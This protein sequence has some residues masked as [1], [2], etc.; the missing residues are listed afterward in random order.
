M[1]GQ[2]GD[3]PQGRSPRRWL[4]ATVVVVAVAVIAFSAWSLHE[5]AEG[6]DPLAWLAGQPA[7]QTTEEVADDSSGSEDVASTAG[8]DAAG[9]G[10]ASAEAGGDATDEATTDDGAEAADDDA[11]SDAPQGQDDP[12][13]ST[14]DAPSGG[15]EP[16]G[17]TSQP[18]EAET[19]AQPEPAQQVPETISVTVTIDGSPAGGSTHT[20]VV[21]LS[22]GA[23]VYEALVAADGNVNARDTVY[24]TYVAA[25]DGLAEKDHGGMSGWVYAVNGVE[26]NTACSNYTL[27]GGESV[28]WTY[29]NVEY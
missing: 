8:E 21:E 6:A 9:A 28:T 23:T 7:L 20:S 18:E 5:Y 13:A 11:P 15:G 19:S 25:I 2:E 4:R 26:P 17:S 24:G 1:Q 27:S 3:R 14:A 16:Q 29:V 22:P 12:S 10:E